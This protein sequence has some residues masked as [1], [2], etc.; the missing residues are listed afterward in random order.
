[1]AVEH[2]KYSDR[3]S[4][5]VFK[6]LNDCDEYFILI[7]S[8][9]EP[10]FNKSLD[11]VFKDYKL[12]LERLEL[13]SDTQVLTRF[14]LSDIQNQKVLLTDSELFEYCQNGAFAIIGQPPAFRGGGIYFLSYH[15]KGNSFKRTKL[16]TINGKEYRNGLLL[17]GN[18]INLL[19]TGGFSGD[20]DLD[21]SRQ[22]R[23]LFSDYQELLACHDMDLL[24][25]C[26]RTWIYVRDIDNHY[27][28]MVEA[29]KKLFDEVNLTADTRYIASTGIE[30][31]SLNV[32]SLVTMDALAIGG[33]DKDQLVRMEA[34]D[35]MCPTN[36]Y[37]VTF[38]RGQNVKFG[39][40]SHLHIS[41]TA[42]IDTTGEVIHLNDVCKQT[43]RAVENVEALLAEHDS[44]LADMLYILVYLR[45]PRDIGKVKDVLLDKIP[46]E[47]PVVYV[48]G[49]VCRPSWL[50]E[51]EGIAII[52]STTQFGDFE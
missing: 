1:M 30:G 52:T 38:E 21:S 26:V 23:E 43:A 35:M 6:G 37:G 20:G 12:V 29:R 39:D 49:S 33:L 5:S 44:V 51:I 25:N 16:K 22:T 46:L 42:S 28:G 11:N 47:M 34:P 48:E 10:D 13:Q 19:F 50:V 15:I 36:D 3:T 2:I 18:N 4:A 9:R 40:R 14:I 17:E 45:N 31:K 27:Q 24:N 7:R 32:N 41:G 8:K